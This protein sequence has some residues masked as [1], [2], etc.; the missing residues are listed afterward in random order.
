MW[1][2]LLIVMTTIKAGGNGITLQLHR[3]HS[4]C[5]TDDIASDNFLIQ[6][7]ITH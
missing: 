5:V 6:C 3:A 4:L 1:A 7:V 2:L